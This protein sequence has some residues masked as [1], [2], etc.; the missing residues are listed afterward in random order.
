MLYTLQFFLPTQRTG[1]PL[2]QALPS[3]KLLQQVRQ[4]HNHGTARQK[5]QNL[6]MLAR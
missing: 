6:I 2:P 1:G 3:C 5:Q 4:E